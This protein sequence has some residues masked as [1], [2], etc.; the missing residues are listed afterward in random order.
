MRFRDFLPI[1]F[2]ALIFLVFITAPASYA[3]EEVLPDTL[4]VEEEIILEEEIFEEE[5]IPE[6]E[7]FEEEFIPEEEIIE[8]EVAPEEEEVV[9]EEAVEEV[10]EEPSMF[11]PGWTAK[12]YVNFGAIEPWGDPGT[13]ALF[14]MGFKGQLGA[15]LN[16]ANWLSLP[17]VLKPLTAEVMAGYTMFNIKS[18]YTGSYEEGKT[19]VISF[20]ALGRYDLTDLIL[21]L[22]G[23]EYPALGIFGVAGFQYNMQSWDFP[24]WTR[25]FD[26][27]SSFGL[28]LGIGVKYN[29][30]QMVG[31]PVEIDLRFTQGVFIMG[32]VKDQDGEPFYPNDDY[33]HTENGILIG[34]AYPF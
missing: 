6:E 32:D 18:D 11:K 8:E 24:N 30:M 5:A 25:E 22:I 3:Q 4:E 16:I 23:F 13:G 7:I 19:N 29:L 31:K 12:V 1:S 14:D 17:T 26:S 21:Q 27:A 9:E 15:Q 10:V 2:V 20:L 34:I 33:N 28:N